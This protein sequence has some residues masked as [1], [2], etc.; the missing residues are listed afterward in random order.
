MASVP[1]VIRVVAVDDHLLL[2]KGIS[3]LLNAEPDMKLVAEASNGEE[4]SRV[5]GHTVPMSLSWTAVARS[6][7]D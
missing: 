3:A 7:R 1:N 2:R 4:V 6:Q 5:S